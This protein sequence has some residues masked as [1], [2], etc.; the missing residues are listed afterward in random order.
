MEMLGKE[1]KLPVIETDSISQS[2]VSDGNAANTLKL[3]FEM[4]KGVFR[5]A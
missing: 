4:C 1:V 2:L 3:S 5:F